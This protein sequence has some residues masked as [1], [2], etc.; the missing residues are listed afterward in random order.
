[1]KGILTWLV[2]WCGFHLS[3]SIQKPSHKPCFFLLFL[4]I[5]KY[6]LQRE[7]LANEKVGFISNIRN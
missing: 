4:L 2:L 1:M 3:F 5:N 7:S 6:N